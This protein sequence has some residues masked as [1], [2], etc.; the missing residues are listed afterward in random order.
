MICYLVR[1]GDEP[2]AL[3]ASIEL[4]R[5]IACSQSQ[6]NY[7]VDEIQADPLD[8]GPRTRARRRSTRRPDGR[9]GMVRG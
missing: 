7:I 9:M 5:E 1:E 8:T 2:V 6:G 3:V 4:A